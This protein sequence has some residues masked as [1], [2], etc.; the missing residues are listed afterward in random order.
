M[1]E[2]GY[3]ALTDYGLAKVLEPGSGK[4]HD[5]VGTPDYLAPEIIN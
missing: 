1:D 3:I 4:L 2:D 5:H